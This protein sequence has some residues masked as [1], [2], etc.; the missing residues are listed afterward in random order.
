M[1]VCVC[2][3]VHLF[4]KYLKTASYGLGLAKK[5]WRDIDEQQ[6]QNFCFHGV[7]RD[8]Q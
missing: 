1:H 4:N 5:H 7:E 6:K 2:V 3:C 8:R